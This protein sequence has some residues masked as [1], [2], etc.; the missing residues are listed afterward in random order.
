VLSTALLVD[1]PAVEHVGRELAALTEEEPA[2]KVRFLGPWP[3][4]SF[5]ALRPQQPA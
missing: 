3:P 2:L 5:A 4:Y 1:E